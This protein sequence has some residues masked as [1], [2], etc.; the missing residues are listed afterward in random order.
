[1]FA[2]SFVAVRV[3]VK[4]SHLCYNKEQ[5][6]GDVMDTTRESLFNRILNVFEAQP[7]WLLIGALLFEIV[8][9]IIGRWLLTIGILN[10]Q[11][12][13][14]MLHSVQ[15]VSKSMFFLIILAFRRY[16]TRFVLYSLFGILALL[17]FSIMIVNL[18]LTGI[19]GYAIDI[20]FVFALLAFGMAVYISVDPTVRYFSKPILIGTTVMLLAFHSNLY[21]MWQYVIYE[22]VATNYASFFRTAVYLMIIGYH[23][24]WLLW[25]LP[26]IYLVKNIDYM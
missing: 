16:E 25:T 22:S 17:F 19:R 6:E 1:M 12:F 23:A 13:T 21:I 5:E 9:E 2:H 14:Y 7:V 18:K 11:T 3:D 20:N 8:Y 10:V 26:Q 4:R 24:V 15:F